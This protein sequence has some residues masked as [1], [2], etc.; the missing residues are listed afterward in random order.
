[1]FISSTLSGKLVF[2]LGFVV[3]PWSCHLCRIK[4]TPKQ[5]KLQITS[6]VSQRIW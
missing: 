1:V 2:G 4:T 5:N 3:G 6:I